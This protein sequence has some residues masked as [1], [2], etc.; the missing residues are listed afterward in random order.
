M[1]RSSNKYTHSNSYV[2]SE[3]YFIIIYITDCRTC[4]MLSL[5]S[6]RYKV[7]IRNEYTSGDPI[8]T[9]GRE[10]V[11][12]CKTSLS[13]FLVSALSLENQISYLLERVNGFIYAL[14]VYK[15]TYFMY[16]GLKISFITMCVFIWY[17]YVYYN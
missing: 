7:L 3:L 12:K 6:E 17:K 5:V 16:L 2:V 15:C 9:M 11:S 13:L 8:T 14:I 10:W 4:Q 1:R